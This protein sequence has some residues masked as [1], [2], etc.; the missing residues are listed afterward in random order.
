MGGIAAVV[1]AAGEASRFGAPKQRLLLPRVLARLRRAPLQEVVVVWG[2]YEL[3]EPVAVEEGPPV[4]LVR[5]PEWARGP[6]ASLRCGLAALAPEVEAAVVVL[7][8]GPALAPEAVERVVASWREQGGLVAASYGGERGHPLVLGRA[9]WGRVPDE[10]LRALASR[11]V[12]C[13][14]LGAPGDVDVPDDLRRMSPDR[15]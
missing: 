3:D 11:L 8:D 12:P 5:C 13:D 10:G 4:R 7:A 9:D 15:S 6:G 1:L 2:R 14:D